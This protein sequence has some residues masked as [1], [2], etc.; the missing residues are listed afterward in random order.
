MTG[1]DPKKL[2]EWRRR[3]AAKEAIVPSYFEVFPERVIIVCGGCREE[4]R[5]N[6]VPNVQEPTFV[7]PNEKCRARNWIPIRY[8]LTL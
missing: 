7:C 5:R 2:A 4:F 1:P 3:A 6:L 8:Q